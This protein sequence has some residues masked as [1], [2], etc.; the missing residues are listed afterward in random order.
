MYKAYIY[1]KYCFSNN[2]ITYLREEI[3]YLYIEDIFS[4]F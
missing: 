2:N 4:L 1:F 3:R